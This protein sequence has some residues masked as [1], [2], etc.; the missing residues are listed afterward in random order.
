MLPS[1]WFCSGN[2]TVHVPETS[3]Y[4]AP[5]WSQAN[6]PLVSVKLLLLLLYYYTQYYIIITGF[7]AYKPI[8]TVHEVHIEVLV[9]QFLYRQRCTFVRQRP[10][11]IRQRR[12]ISVV[13]RSRHRNVDSVRSCTDTS[14][15]LPPLK[16]NM[17]P[18]SEI[19]MNIRD[20]TNIM[21]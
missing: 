14:V 19:H 20:A 18:H 10:V 11:C 17:W 7:S 8:I 15:S 4:T 21:S 2:F 6:W 9:M 16:K 3:C 13:L 1:I 5:C 12:N